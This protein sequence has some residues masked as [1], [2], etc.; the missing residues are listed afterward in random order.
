MRGLFKKLASISKHLGRERKV[1]QH[2]AI[3]L[4]VLSRQPSYTSH[5][6]DWACRHI[7]KSLSEG[8]IRYGMKGRRTSST[9]L[10]LF[11]LANFHHD[12]KPFG[13]L[14][15]Y[16]FLYSNTAWGN[17]FD[18]LHLVSLTLFRYLPVS[19]NISSTWTVK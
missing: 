13:G 1:R 11:C 8:L 10:I 19:H 7:L 14:R 18:C 16:R 15:P 17:V 2:I 9:I 12:S 6:H 5:A 3:N 4:V